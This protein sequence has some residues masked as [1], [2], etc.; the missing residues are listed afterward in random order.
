MALSH[1]LIA[2]SIGALTLAV[3]AQAAAPVS[4]GWY[5]R[6]VVAEENPAFTARGQ[7]YKTVDIAPCGNDF[8]GVSVGDGG[9]CGAVLF[10]FLGHRAAT[11]DSLQ[12]HGRWGTGRKNVM[13]YSFGGDAVPRGFELY[14]GD[15]YDFG[16]R[17]DNMPKFHAEY[18]RTGAA[19][20][21]AR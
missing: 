12:G 20:C 18:R 5:G 1:R 3:G 14:L 10:R 16:G 2:L 19:Q 15:G 13:L 17:S 7:V 4:S 6:W 9:R 8:C 11:D 21:M